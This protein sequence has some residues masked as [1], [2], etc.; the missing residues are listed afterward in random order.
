MLGGVGSWDLEVRLRVRRG[1]CG[2]CGGR[3]RG[4]R[5]E[6]ASELY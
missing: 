5:P 3:A 4:R 6:S 1:C 2:E